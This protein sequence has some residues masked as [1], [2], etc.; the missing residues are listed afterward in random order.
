MFFITLTLFF[1]ENMM[2]FY[3][4]AQPRLVFWDTCCNDWNLTSL[5][6]RDNRW[7]VHGFAML[8]PYPT[9]PTP[10]ILP[11]ERR[12]PSIDV[13]LRKGDA[14]ICIIGLLNVPGNRCGVPFARIKFDIGTFQN[15]DFDVGNLLRSE[16]LFREA[17]VR[18][19]FEAMNKKLQQQQDS[20]MQS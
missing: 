3:Y 13:V 15:D 7:R 4:P 14:L 1:K 9:Y 6:Y 18:H 16:Q 8:K 20:G 12:T 5:T 10:D 2:Q 19:F 11:P 17:S